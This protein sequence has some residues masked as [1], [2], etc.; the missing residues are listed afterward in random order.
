MA[1]EPVQV[2]LYTDPSCPWAYSAEP[3]LRG[4]E[5][6][7]GGGLSWRTVVIG[8]SEDTRARERAGV[9]PESRVA[10]WKEY[11][12][13]FGMPVSSTPRTRLI[14][15]GRA[16]R[17]VK[18]AERLGTGDEL[19]RA[20]RLA[21]FTTTQLLD[22][23]EA[24]GQVASAAGLDGGAV[25][26]ALDDPDVE[27]AYQYDRA[28]ARSM[29]PTGAPAI[30]QGRAAVSEPSARFTAPSLVFTRGADT[31][32]AGGWQPFEAY[33]LCVSNLAPELPRRPVPEPAEL[34]A[35]FPAGLTTVEVAQVCR[36]RNDDPD[37]G[38]TSATLHQLARA[39][40]VTRTPIGD[41]RSLW[42]PIS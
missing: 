28:E 37:P 26:A 40:K 33:D 2:T 9:T 41:D 11:E 13:R 23:D 32:V 36:E 21:W 14:A 18:A 17:A 39:G 27:S 34:L 15:S 22:E 6:R 10:G 4:L 20:L 30:A 16:C 8:L 35:R 38:A 19:L 1:F 7:Y 31:L 29:G 12:R 25:V 24:I 42:Q 5:W 3:F